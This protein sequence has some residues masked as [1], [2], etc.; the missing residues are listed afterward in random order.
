MHQSRVSQAVT[1]ITEQSNNPQPA[2]LTGQSCT[3][4]TVLDFKRLFIS[5][6]TKY[7]VVCTSYLNNSFSLGAIQK[8][9]E[10]NYVEIVLICVKLK[11]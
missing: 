8:V 10:L 3:D 6:P 1:A 9:L 5:N 4:W 2:V 7:M 11:S